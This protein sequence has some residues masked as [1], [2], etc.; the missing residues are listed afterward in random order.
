M[1][2]QPAFPP[3]QKTRGRGRKRS[4][5]SRNKPEYETGKEK[6]KRHD[7]HAD[8]QESPSADLQVLPSQGDE[9]ENRCQGSGL[10]V[11]PASQLLVEIPCRA[12]SRE[13]A[14][15][16]DNLGLL[17]IIKIMIYGLSSCRLHFKQ[18][19]RHHEKERYE[20]TGKYCR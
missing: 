9:L 10:H 2:P 7:Y 18:T 17:H 5:L 6:R 19:H 13:S 14:T 1:N 12:Q 15:G 16:N 8:L 4:I 3:N 20:Q 11:R